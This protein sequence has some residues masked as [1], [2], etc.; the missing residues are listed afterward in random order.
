MIT[1]SIIIV[2]FNDES[3]LLTC[4]ESI[5]KNT[6]IS[7]EIIVVD[8]AN[9]LSLKNKL[10]KL[11]PKVSYLATQEN[12]GYGAA[13]NIGATH[14]KGKFIFVLNPDTLLFN[15]TIENLTNFLQDHSDVG[16]VSPLL[17]DNNKIP[18]SKQGTE[19]LTPITAIFSLSRI[20]KYFPNNYIAKQYWLTS[21]DKKNPREVGVSPGTAML[22]PNSLY[23]KLNGFDSNIFIYYEECDLCLRAMNLGYK[24]CI[25]PSAKLI[26]YWGQSTPNATLNRHRM[27][28][29]RN[30]YMNK[31]FGPFWRSVVNIICG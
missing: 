15:K 26:H 18:Y 6:S 2:S 30:Y 19:K 25:L 4:I 16:I 10:H 21:W 17:L 29:S 24:T 5:I 12:L 8:N 9:L 14:A 3:F 7:F 20:H 1:V 27:K 22:L 11:F 23:K 13:C 31:H 28:V